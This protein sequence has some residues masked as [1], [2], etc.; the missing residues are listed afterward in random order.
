MIDLCRDCLLLVQDNGEAVPCSAED[1]TF[2]IVGASSISHDVLRHCAAGILHYFKADLGRTRI[3]LAEFSGALVRIL[4]GFGYDIEVTGVERGEASLPVPRAPSSGPLV[5]IHAVDLQ[6]LAAEAGKM[7]ELGFFPR[8]KTVL[9]QGLSGGCSTVDC[10]GLRPAVKQLLGRKQWSPACR[11][12]EQRIVE[13]LRRW[14]R[15]RTQPPA[16]G[17]VV[18]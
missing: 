3:T 17:L 10:H 13:T 18:R 11:E 12:L 4:A 6:G 1:L 16:A 7:G 14:Y 2:E 5:P 15:C 9:D 8:L